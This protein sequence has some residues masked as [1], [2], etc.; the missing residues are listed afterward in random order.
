MTAN[1]TTLAHFNTRT[2]SES[3]VPF[4]LT[5]PDGAKAY[6][7]D[8]AG[9]DH[10]VRLILMGKDSKTYRKHY[11]LIQTKLGENMR[12]GKTGFADDEARDLDLDLYSACTVGWE[13]MLDESGEPIEFSQT[14]ARELYADYPVIYE[15]VI[16]FVSDRA[17]FLMAS[18]NG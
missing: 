13:N 3:G 8:A 11:S 4:H 1:K 12:A 14:K 10:P 9:V 5:T 16:R 7:Q 6:I 17:N 2:K 18:K 15:Q